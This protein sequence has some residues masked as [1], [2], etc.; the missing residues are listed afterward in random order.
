MDKQG[1][2]HF[3][4]RNIICT[5]GYRDK[6]IDNNSIFLSNNKVGLLILQFWMKINYLPLSTPSLGCTAYSWRLSRLFFL[7]LCTW[8]LGRP[9]LQDYVH[10]SCLSWINFE[11]D[12]LLQLYAYIL[13]LSIMH[14]TEI[15]KFNYCPFLKL[16]YY[17]F[18]IVII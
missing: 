9:I 5:Q 3:K 14:K 10:C 1:S 16:S 17:T 8:W 18:I 6:T 13:F 4:Y 11:Q 12:T 2:L 15:L 7:K